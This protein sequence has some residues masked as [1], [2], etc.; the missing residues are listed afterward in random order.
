MSTLRVDAPIVMYVANDEYIFFC[1]H[2]EKYG[3]LSQWYESAF[4]LHGGEYHFAEQAM[5]AGKAKLFGDEETLKKIIAA[6]D[7]RIIKDLGRQV[8]GFVQQT[9]DLH[10]Y[11]IVLEN[12]RCKFGQNSELARKLLETGDK[13]LVEAADYD[14]V[15]GIGLSVVEAAASLESEWLGENLLGKILMQVRAELTSNV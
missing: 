4:I 14:R 6:A 1:S 10:K 8:K 9:W 5:M 3:F 7:P 2:K 12:N 15:W 11:N 13:K